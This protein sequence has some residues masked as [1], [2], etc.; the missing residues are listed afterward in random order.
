MGETEVAMD[1]PHIIVGVDEHAVLFSEK[2]CKLLEPWVWT[3]LHVDVG[4]RQGCWALVN[5]N[6][7]GELLHESHYFHPKSKY[8]RGIVV[9]LLSEA[10]REKLPRSFVILDEPKEW[11]AISHQTWGFGGM[12]FT[13]FEEGEDHYLTQEEAWIAMF[14][15]MGDKCSEC[16]LPWDQDGSGPKLGSLRSCWMC[17]K[18]AL[19]K[20]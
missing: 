14:E 17:G 13:F 3:Y 6:E 5:R 7:Q 18:P 4:V 12:N 19:E 10:V 20:S 8:F 1:K 15:G 2:V 11:C 9:H 16:Q